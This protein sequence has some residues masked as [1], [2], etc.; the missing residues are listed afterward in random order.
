M[1]GH[2]K[3]KISKLLKSAAVPEQKAGALL[4]FDLDEKRRCYL[5]ESFVLKAEAGLWRSFR[6]EKKEAFGVYYEP[7]EGSQAR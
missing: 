4:P 2:F 5:G 7:G 3:V 6:R 1:V